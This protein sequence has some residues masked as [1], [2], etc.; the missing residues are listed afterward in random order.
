MQS[1]P[2]VFEST[3][4]LDMT[5]AAAEPVPVTFGA[6]SLSGQLCTVARMTGLVL[7]AR[8]GAA[9]Q[10]ACGNRHLAELLHRCGIGTLS[11]DLLTERELADGQCGLDI[12]LQSWRIGQAVLWAAGCRPLPRGPYG[13]AASDTGAAAALEFAATMPG[14][15]AAV[16]SCSGR[17]ELAW[18]LLPRVRAPTL[19]MIGDREPS[20]TG[21][22]RAAMRELKC[23]K[24]LELIPHVDGPDAE[25]G[26]YEDV[27]A[28]Y[29]AAQWLQEHMRHHRE[30]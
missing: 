19:L 15:V 8:V 4:R 28:A 3:D 22:H 27:G 24:R 2:A 16:V 5:P 7:L 12:A 1:A 10:R 30:W 20:V 6:A 17:P 9:D 11:F 13:L 21:L 14:D 26:I 18:R 29:L 25:S 23:T